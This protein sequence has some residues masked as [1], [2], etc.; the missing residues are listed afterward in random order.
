[1][2]RF[3]KGQT[4]LVLLEIDVS[5]LRAPVKHEPADADVFPHLY[6]PL[7]LDAVVGTR[8]LAAGEDGGFSFRA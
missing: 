3:F 7:N 2:E 5:K 1:M 6:G 4:G 8:P